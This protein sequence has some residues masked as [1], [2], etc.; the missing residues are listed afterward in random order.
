MGKITGLSP[1]TLSKKRLWHRYFPV[2]FAKC[3]KT[4]FSQNTFGACFL[5]AKNHFKFA[6]YFMLTFSLKFSRTPLIIKELIKDEN[7]FNKKLFHVRES[8][9]T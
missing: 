9:K 6:F 4:P 5:N 3:L 8:S 2:S 1:E 7:K